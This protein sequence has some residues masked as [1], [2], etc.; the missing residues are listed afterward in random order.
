[1]FAD[2]SKRWQAGAWYVGDVAFAGSEWTI[3]FETPPT[4]PPDET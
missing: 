4:G 3:V 1:V 2:P